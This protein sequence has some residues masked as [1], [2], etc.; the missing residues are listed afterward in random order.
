[1]TQW[2]I[3]PRLAVSELH[4]WPNAGPQ[5]P[6]TAKMFYKKVMKLLFGL[7]TSSSDWKHVHV[8]YTRIMKLSILWSFGSAQV[9]M[10]VSCSAREK[11]ANLSACCRA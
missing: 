10:E 1:M 11:L 3:E 8:N 4:Y 6:P 9:H 2:G 7:K 5:C